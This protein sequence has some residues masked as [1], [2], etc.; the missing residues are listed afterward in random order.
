[1]ITENHANSLRGADERTSFADMMI[2]SEETCKNC[3]PLTPLACVA[4]CSVWKMKNEFRKLCEKMR[5][6]SFMTEL[7]NTLK[8]ARRLQIL[9]IISKGR[10][11]IARLQQ[12]LKKQGYYHS[13]QTIAEEY[14]APLIEVGLAEENQKQ[15]CTTHFGCRL[16]ELI[17][18]FGG[19]K[20]ILPPHSECYEEMALVML[21]NEPRTYGDFEGVIPAKSVARVLNRLQRTRLIETS[22][23][24]DYVFF[25]QTKRDPNRERL[26]PTERR[27][28]E[29]TLLEG[30]SARRLAEETRISLRR[31]YKYLR[32]LRGKKL[33]FT[34]KRPKSYALTV[35]G[36]QI[37]KM[38]EGIRCLTVELLAAAAQL[39]KGGET[40]P[41]QTPDTIQIEREKKEKEILSLTTIQGTKRS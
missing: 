10:Y 5:S 13:R 38:L 22:K 27:V 31:T 8:N 4:S 17:K 30:I 15:Y 21:L 24:N 11:S 14:I 40:H 39:V 7:M 32:R 41:M 2:A 26:S 19:I 18:E 29:N 9:E 12:E 25:F 28:Y 6:P 37:A 33:I 36:I 35:K 3:H 23:E 1:M 34:R 20:D 16:N